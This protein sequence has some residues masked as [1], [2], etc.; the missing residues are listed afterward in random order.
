M[1][2]VRKCSNC[3]RTKIRSEFREIV[4]K[5]KV[6]YD[7]K[8]PFAEIKK[9]HNSL[10]IRKTC[11]DCRTNNE[12][13]RYEK[14]SKPYVPCRDYVKCECSKIVSVANINIHR[15]SKYHKERVEHI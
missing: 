9:E 6:S 8:P 2:K 10:V 1:S 15:Q 4:T 5:T 7:D 13:Y 11:R 3:Q 14:P 12:K